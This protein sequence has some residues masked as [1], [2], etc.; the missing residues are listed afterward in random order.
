M[1]RRDHAPLIT[2]PQAVVGIITEAVRSDLF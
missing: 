1:G 2:R